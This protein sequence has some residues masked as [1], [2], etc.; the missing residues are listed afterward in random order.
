MAGLPGGDVGLSR[1]IQRAFVAFRETSPQGSSQNWR[2]TFGAY[3]YSHE[4][5]QCPPARWD[6]RKPPILAKVDEGEAY[7]RVGAGNGESVG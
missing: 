7:R 5:G 4:K 2:S 6:R 3:L 1:I